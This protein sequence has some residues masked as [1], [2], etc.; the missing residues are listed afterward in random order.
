MTGTFSGSFNETRTAQT[1]LNGV[2]VLTTSASAKGKV[3]VNIC[4]NNVTH[5]SLTYNS[6]ENVITCT[7]GSGAL[8]ASGRLS[9]DALS[10]NQINFA[11]YPNPVEDGKFKINLPIGMAHANIMIFDLL[12]KLIYQQNSEGQQSVEVRTTLKAGLYVVKVISGSV[13]LSGKLVVK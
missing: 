8:L 13:Y 3:T 10:N 7:G 9:E 6:T 5:G 1:D 12:G 11:I 4:V 2:A